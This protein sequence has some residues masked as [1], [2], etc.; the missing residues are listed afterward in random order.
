MITRNSKRLWLTLV[1]FLGL[2][3]STAQARHGEGDPV[4]GGGPSVSAS[5]SAIRGIGESS[6]NFGSV[7]DALQPDVKFAG[8]DVILQLDYLWHN[9][10]LFHVHSGSMPIY[11]GL[12]GDLS[13]TDPASFGVRCLSAFPTSSGTGSPWIS[14]PRWFP[15][16]GSP[17][18]TAPSIFM[19]TWE[20]VFTPKHKETLAVRH[21]SPKTWEEKLF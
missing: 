2:S 17:T 20:F 7:T 10:H 5:S 15:R 13:S 3:V 12:G 14:M 8:R 19:A 11:I 18:G 1:F 6:G 9:Y 21:L 16:F 4:R